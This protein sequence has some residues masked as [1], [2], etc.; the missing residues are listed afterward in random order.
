MAV[1]GQDDFARY[2]RRYR[3]AL[4][5]FDTPAI[6][7]AMARR[8]ATAQARDFVG[9]LTLVG[10]EWLSSA[11]RVGLLA[12]SMN[13]LTRAHVALADA[14]RVAGRLDALCWVAT[15]VTVDKEEV[16][17][18]SLSDR[19]LAADLYARAMGD[20]LL[21]LRGG[22]YV[23]QAR[24]AHALLGS[25][26][27]VALV[28]GFDKVVQIFDSRYYPDRDAALRELF[29]ETALLVAPREGYAEPELKA[30]LALPE[31]RPFA[32]RVAYFPLPE[33]F[34]DDSSTEA[35]ALAASG[36]YGSRLRELLAPEGLA[37]AASQPYAQIQPPGPDD[38]GD[39]YS[40]RQRLIL[41][42][43]DLAPSDLEEIPPIHRLVRWSAEAGV[44]GAK[45]RAWV[46]AQPP[47]SLASLRAALDRE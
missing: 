18:A 39:A 46:N 31:N 37:L 26:V 22:L 27:E 47:R 35:R 36:V 2:E 13:P 14:A 32:E 11:S 6:A 28:V 8:V 5:A 30:L 45:L 9:G 33:R 20:G 44:R 7:V 15:T 38:L 4:S 23:E 34:M 16:T 43:G 24:A 19:L 12:T 41:A 3:T 1:S 25:G 10:A 42:L 21:L 29:A 17:R 40:A